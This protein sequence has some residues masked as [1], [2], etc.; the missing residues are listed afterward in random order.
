MNRRYKTNKAWKDFDNDLK[1]LTKILDKNQFPIFQLNLLIRSQ[2]KYLNLKFYK[3]LFENNNNNSKKKKPERKADIRFFKMTGYCS[4]I[5]QKK[6]QN[7]PK[8]L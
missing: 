3:K 1:N 5:A 8:T 2:K 4:N 7:L 6:I